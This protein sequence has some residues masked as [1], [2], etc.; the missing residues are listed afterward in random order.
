MTHQPGNATGQ[1]RYQPGEFLRRR[2]GPVMHTG[3]S[4]GDGRVLH[5]TPGRGEHVSTLEEFAKGK[6][7]RVSPGSADA[8]MRIQALDEDELQ[9]PYNL[10][11]NNCEHTASRVTAGQPSSP[12]LKKV[13]VEALIGAALLLVLRRPLLA[14]G[15]RVGS[16]VVKKLAKALR[17]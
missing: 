5:N 2:K 17:N 13:A 3:V 8:R 7:L 14:F 16:R 12:Q 9:R 10:F 1:G 6:T 4:L 11:L 15:A